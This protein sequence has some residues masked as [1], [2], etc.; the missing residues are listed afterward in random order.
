MFSTDLCFTDTT[1][2]GGDQSSL[3][4]SKEVYEA[5]VRRLMVILDQEQQARLRVED[6]LDEARVRTCCDAALL[7][8]LYF[9]C[10]AHCVCIEEAT[11]QLPCVREFSLNYF[12]PCDVYSLHTL[13]QQILRQSAKL[14]AATAPANAKKGGFLQTL[15]GGGS[16][17][18][19]QN[20]TQPS[21]HSSAAAAALTNFSNLVAD[22]ISP[23]ANRRR[24]S[25]SGA[26]GFITGATAEDNARR[27]NYSDR[28]AALAETLEIAQERIMDLVAEMESH[29]EAQNIVLETKES[30]LRSLAR[31]NTHLAME[32]GQL[33]SLHCF[34]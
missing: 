30:V 5:H 9:A 25:V 22:T 18:A 24:D 26:P 3:Y 19:G 29:Q 7:Y 11:T 12:A 31:Q 16:G 17:S 2:T 33:K 10:D 21:G 6:K 4:H 28:E 13:Q 8:F 34:N 15:F 32:V 1:D 14:Q 23:N 20:N 27:F